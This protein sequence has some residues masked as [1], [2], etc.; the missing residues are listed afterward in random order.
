MSATNRGGK[1]VVNDRYFT[2]HWLT[3]AIL[4]HIGERLSD[5]RPL[6]ILEPAFGDG[7]IVAPLKSYLDVCGFAHDVSVID[8]TPPINIDFLTHDFGNTRFDLIITNPPY[9]LA[10]E[11]VEKSMEIRRDKNSIVCM[12]LR[13]G[14]LG[15]KKR[16]TWLRANTPSVYI[17][18]KRPSFVNGGNDNCEYGWFIWQD[19][20]EGQNLHFLKTDHIKGR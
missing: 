17:T 8:I 10:M 2:P 1:R 5:N 7:H 20:W 11:F 14:F 4:P 19:S 18:P 13:I 9:S 3:E 16:A 15:S 12:L 6:K